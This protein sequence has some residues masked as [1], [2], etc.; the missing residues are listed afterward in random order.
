VL[1]ESEKVQVHDIGDVFWIDVDDRGAVSRAE[2]ALIERLPKLADG[3][4][5]R[6][7]NRPLS[8]RISRRLVTRS[9]TPNQIS[10]FCFGL[11]LLAA[12]LF[13]VG[14]TLTLALG[15][16][17][18]QFSSVLDGCDGEIARLRFRESDFGGWFDAVLDR[19]SDAFLLFG[20]TWHVFA[21]QGNALVLAVGFLAI[22]GSFMC[23]YT[24]DKHDSLMR[25]RFEQST[26]GGM[27]IG[28]DL[29]VLVIA[30]GAVVNLPFLALSLIAAI[31]N[32]ETVRRV[33]VARDPRAA[34]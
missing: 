23:S 1:A 15:G 10:V 34:G 18:A 12:A 25:D 13:A 29:R 30:I 11:S 3:P 2:R 17:L 26:V 6:Y 28:R 19:Y 4:I 21:A 32:L 9:V 8:T 31:M 33:V 5:A 27:R 7:L 24:A 14:G 20:L 22:T 16:L